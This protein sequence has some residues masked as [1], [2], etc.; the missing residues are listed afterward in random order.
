MFIMPWNTLGLAQW[1][2]SIVHYKGHALCMLWGYHNTV[3]L[4]T[5]WD[6]VNLAL[7]ISIFL[8]PTWD[9]SFLFVLNDENNLILLLQFKAVINS[10]R[11][12]LH[13]R[14]PHEYHTFSNWLPDSGYTVIMLLFLKCWALTKWSCWMFW[15]GFRCNWALTVKPRT[16]C[17]FFHL[18]PVQVL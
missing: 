15:C 2:C 12:Q 5:P 9:S 13:P 17:T 3:A 4:S 11:V 10:E 6:T 7:C 8:P 1:Y 14:S 16:L 18:D